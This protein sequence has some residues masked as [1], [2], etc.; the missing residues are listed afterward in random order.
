MN[1]KRIQYHR[2]NILI[3]AMYDVVSDGPD[4]YDT[5]IQILLYSYPA[6]L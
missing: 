5:G 3:P 4:N 2:I 1:N 6:L